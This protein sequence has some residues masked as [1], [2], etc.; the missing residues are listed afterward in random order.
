MERSSESTDSLSLALSNRRTKLS[1]RLP[2]AKTNTASPQTEV[3]LATR[4]AVGVLCVTVYSPW[5]SPRQPPVARLNTSTFLYSHRS[6][7]GFHLLLSLTN[8]L[9]KHNNRSITTALT[10]FC[11]EQT[12]RP[13]PYIPQSRQ[14]GLGVCRHELRTHQD[15]FCLITPHCGKAACFWEVRSGGL[16]RRVNVTPRRL[17]LT[18]DTVNI[19]RC[20]VFPSTKV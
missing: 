10:G 12:L 8:V 16:Y 14:Q 7:P 11:P 13:R 5:S 18:V 6:I 17:L 15:R 20:K 19:W 9:P 3:V 4:H 1:P 2:G